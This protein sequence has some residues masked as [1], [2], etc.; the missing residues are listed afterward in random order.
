MTVAMT[1][2]TEVSVP[3]RTVYCWPLLVYIVL[4]AAGHTNANVEAEGDGDAT[5][6]LGLLPLE[7]PK[8]PLKTPVKRS[9]VPPTRLVP[10]LTAA[11]SVQVRVVESKVEEAHWPFE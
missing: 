1:V 11:L 2:P 4:F 6:G 8:R 3:H 10:E 7:P 5:E 9:T